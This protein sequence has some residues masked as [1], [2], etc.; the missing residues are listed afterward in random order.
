MEKAVLAQVPMHF[1]LVL[2]HCSKSPEGTRFLPASQG[3]ARVGGRLPL[4]ADCSYSGPCSVVS[5]AIRQFAKQV[6]G[7]FLPWSDGGF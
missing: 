7:R 4:W 5:I 1:N 6:E 3:P 2:C